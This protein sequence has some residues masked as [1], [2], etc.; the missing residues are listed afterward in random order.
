MTDYS[1]YLEP[2]WNSI[3]NPIQSENDRSEKLSSTKKKQKLGGL[4]LDWTSGIDLIRKNEKV[5]HNEYIKKVNAV[6]F[7]IMLSL[8]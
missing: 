6:N 4:F 5:V 8:C 1:R 2:T 3:Y 7:K